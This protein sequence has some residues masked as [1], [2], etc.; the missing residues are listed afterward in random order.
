MTSVIRWALVATMLGL[1]TCPVPAATQVGPIDTV[2]APKVG[3]QVLVAQQSARPDPVIFDNGNIYTVYN[4]PTSVPGFSLDR[5]TRITA[6]TTYHWNNG[7]GARPGAIA[8]IDSRG[9]IYGPWVATG[10]PGQGGVRD[11]YWTVRPNLSLQAGRYTVI[12]SDMFTW[13]HNEGTGGA[14]IVH[15]E[16]RQR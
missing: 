2:A 1:T 10:A 8:L 4:Q 15:I 12:D 6:I 14:G 9:R 7:N 5:R 13:S 11:A 16:G 3:P